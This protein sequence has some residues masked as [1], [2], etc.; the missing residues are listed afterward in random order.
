MSVSFAQHLMAMCVSLVMFKH[1]ANGRDLVP[2]IDW[3]AGAGVLQA[4]AVIYV[5][6]YRGP[7]GIPSSF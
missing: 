7:D 4:E 3:A 5:G 2:T 6:D 1:P